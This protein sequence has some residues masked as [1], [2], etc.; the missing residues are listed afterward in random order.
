MVV[1]TKKCSSSPL[2]LKGELCNHPGELLPPPIYTATVTQSAQPHPSSE[3]GTPIL[4][5]ETLHQFFRENLCYIQ[6]ATAE[7][8]NTLNPKPQGYVMFYP[9]PAVPSSL[10]ECT[11]VGL[12][13]SFLNTTWVSITRN[14]AY[15]LC[16]IK[17]DCNT[18]RVNIRCKNFHT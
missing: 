7:V 15:F 1:S 11:S 16:D 9:S 2:H 4:S 10:K 17:F 13:L 8:A 14:F 3:P 12:E 5:Y 18:I 6:H